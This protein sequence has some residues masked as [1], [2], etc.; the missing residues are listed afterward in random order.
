MNQLLDRR[1]NDGFTKGTVQA[2]ESIVNTALIASGCAAV[3]SSAVSLASKIAVLAVVIRRRGIEYKEMK[4]GR[5]ALA[6][7]KT[8]SPVVFGVCPLVGCYLLT[9]SDTSAIV[10]SCISTGTPTM[11]WMNQVEAN[12]KFL[13][14]ILDKAKEFVTDS[15]W[16]I[17]GPNISSK[18]WTA[19]SRPWVERFWLS[20]MG[21][22]NRGYRV[23]HQGN[24]I[25]NKIG[26]LYDKIKQPIATLVK[27]DLQKITEWAYGAP[28]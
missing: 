6:S 4:A 8:L 23:I 16:R 22:M 19:D 15:V 11:G 27:K 5:T 28:E 14:P 12:K 20:R 17:Q 10:L 18:A 7:P 25:R 26:G 21:A 24:V 2:V 3:A 13:D 9:G 1:A